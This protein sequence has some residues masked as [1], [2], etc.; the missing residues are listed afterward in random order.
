[1]PRYTIRYIGPAGAHRIE[2]EAFPDDRQALHA[3]R[4]RRA[5]DEAV[6]IRRDGLLVA[7]L[8]APTPARW[9]HT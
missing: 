2:R 3:A 8:G 6:D 5:E 4:E 1:M 9:P 7:K